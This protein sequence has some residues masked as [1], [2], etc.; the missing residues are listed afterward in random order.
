MTADIY[1]LHGE[2]FGDPDFC[3]FRIYGG[4]DYGLPSPGQIELYQHDPD[5]WGESFFDITYQIEF[6]GCPG[7]QLSDYYGITTATLRLEQGG[8]NWYEI[9]EPATSNP[10]SNAFMAE[11]GPGNDLLYGDG[12]DAYGEGWYFYPMVVPGWWN[13]WFYDHPFTYERYKTIHIEFD[14][15]PTGMPNFAE[16][17]INWSTDQWS[18][19]QPPNDSAP[20]LP[21]VDEHLY[22]GRHTVLAG[23]MLE[24]H[25]IF[26]Y[27]I[28]DYNPEW[29]SVDIRGENF[30]IPAGI[31]T[32][33]CVSD[34]PQSLD[35]AFVIASAEGPC[36]CDVGN[37]NGD[38]TIN[39]LD[40]TYLIAYLYMGGPAPTPY[41]IC[42]GDANCNCTVNILDITY[43]IAFLYQSGPPPCTCAQWLINCGSPLR[44]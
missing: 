43:L 26:D 28:P 15:F 7:S 40:I 4:T 31:I 18:L 30:V 27:T 13:I 8:T 14:L 6:E 21:G 9:F 2:L 29:V 19:D 3:T 36:D 44:K 35:L 10:I 1:R 33:E 32:H 17:A 42:S 37:A 25:F 24:G 12:E 5:W 34:D 23:E 20:P 16:V 11:M 22:I 41:P 38:L 39:I